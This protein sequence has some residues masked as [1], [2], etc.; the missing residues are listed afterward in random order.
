MPRGGTEPGN[1]RGGRKK[2]TPN[3]T[4]VERALVAEQVLARAEMR[5]EK[6][7][8]E[9]LNEF[10]KTF[11]GMAATY[12][13]LPPGVMMAPSGRDPN[14]PMFEKYARLAVDTAHKLAAYQSPTFKAILMPTPVQEPARPTGDNVIDITDPNAISRA[15]LK[16][17]KAS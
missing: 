14:E 5:G 6:L 8:K 4:T 7:A 17:V 3:K 15:Y 1:R 13:P 11:A 9:V 16:M 12:Q 2:G 10:M